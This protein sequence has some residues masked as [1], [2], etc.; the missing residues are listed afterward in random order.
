MEARFRTCVSFLLLGSPVL[1]EVIM[2]ITEKSG[3]SGRTKTFEGKRNAV[4]NESDSFF[5][6]KQN[7]HTVDEQIIQG[8][9]FHNQEC[10]KCSCFMV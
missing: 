10:H 7:V 9:R 3:V 4:C 2:K 1:V 5:F 8:Y 6:L